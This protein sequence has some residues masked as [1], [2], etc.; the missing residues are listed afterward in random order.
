LEK[1]AN[2]SLSRLF[3]SRSER[4][5]RSGWRLAGQLALLLVFLI[6]FG[7][8]VGIFLL[9]FPEIP[10]E[11]ILILDRTLT[12][13]AITASVFIARRLLDRRPIRSLGLDWNHRAAR[14][15]VF[16]FLLAGLLL[17]LV[18]LIEWSAGWLRFE[19][20]AWET[21]SWPA[22]I[23]WVAALFIGFVLVGWQEE[24]VA[25]GYW[26]QNISEGLDLSWGVAISSGLFALAHVANPNADLQSFIGLLAAGLF[27]SIG[28]LRTRQLW[29][30][31][32]L[33]TGWNFFEGPVFGFPVSGLQLFRLVR[34]QVEGPELLTGGAFGPEAGLIQL[35]VLLVGAGLILIYTRSRMNKAI[36]DQG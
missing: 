35:P 3:F 17:G 1:P 24:L 15:L 33:H 34:H 5:L 31:I 30:P 23:G 2:S 14:D 29:L 25:R 12:F 28:Y 6:L 36:G 4:R 8:P 22:V 19:G 9:A 32:G 27:L 13:L 11:R 20:F 10:W 21:E 16:G 7:I 18:Y 26:L